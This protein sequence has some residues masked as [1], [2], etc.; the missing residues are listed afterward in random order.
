MQVATSDNFVN[1]VQPDDV[2]LHHR[3]SLDLDNGPQSTV[4]DKLNVGIIF[5]DHPFAPSP[6]R[7]KWYV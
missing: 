2:V 6:T 1:F 5:F 3:K 4:N 7:T